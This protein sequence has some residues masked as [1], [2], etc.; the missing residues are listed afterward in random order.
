MAWSCTA[1]R[2]NWHYSVDE[3]LHIISGEVF[4]TD[5]KGQTHR[6]AAGDMVFFPA[7][8]SS[9]WNVPNFVRKIAF[10]RHSMP[11]PAGRALRVWNKIARRLSGFPSGAATGAAPRSGEQR[12]CRHQG[13][14]YRGPIAGAPPF[15]LSSSCRARPY[16][17]RCR[18]TKE[19]PM[20]KT[21]GVLHFTIPVKNL[22]RCGKLLHRPARL[23]ESRPHR[24]HRF[25]ARGRRLFQSDLFGEPDHAQCRRRAPNSFGVPRHA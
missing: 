20:P 13:R 11:R 15:R 12:R 8:T 9:V 17:V 18:G 7:G 4:V 25:P 3:T 5:E 19:R 24:P 2:F 23:R 16:G 10:C 22:D 14:W 21:E 1:G 6:L